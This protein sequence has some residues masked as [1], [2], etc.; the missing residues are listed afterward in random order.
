MAKILIVEDDK[1]IR[2]F[3]TTVIIRGGFDAAEA[4]DG[5][6][7][8]D[9]MEK[10]HI[11]MVVSDIMMPNMDGFELVKN[12]RTT[13]D[14]IPL[15]LLTARGE[16]IDKN[17]GLEL[18]ADD[19]L[20]KPVD[21]D[22]LILRIRGL[23][24]RA[25]ISSD[26][27]IIFSGVELDERAFSITK[28]MELQTLPQKEFL[29]LFKLLSNPNVVYTRIQLMDEIW[30]FETETSDHT[31]NV[32]IARLRERFYDWEEFEIQTVRGIGYKG[33]RK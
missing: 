8:L 10:Q 7:A 1:N 33:V 21:K 27:R 12:I 22:E 3:L 20:T 30:G 2:K 4:S 5:L 17:K 14:N 15:L 24:R 9:L 16:Q 11:D 13:Y 26:K 31:L 32:H 25:K 19:Y 6:E 29:L 18:G 23:L 28:G